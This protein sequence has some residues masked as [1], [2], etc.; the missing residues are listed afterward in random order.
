MLKISD[1]I[2]VAKE[3][4]C[5]D[6]GDLLSLEYFIR[7]FTTPN[8]EALYG[9]RI[10]KRYP[11]GGLIEREETRALSCSIA[12][13]AALVEAFAAGTVM[14]CVLHEMI[15]ECFCPYERKLMTAI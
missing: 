2:V 14:P 13:V 12:D 1:V 15:E 5:T 6:D 3:T 9:M 8:G 10:D 7:S 11:S 4:V